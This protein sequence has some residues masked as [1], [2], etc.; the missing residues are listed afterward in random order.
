MRAYQHKT[1]L[2]R[3]ALVF[4]VALSGCYGPLQIPGI[5]P[6]I[7]AENPAS[8]PQKIWQSKLPSPPKEIL[9]LNDQKALITTFRGELF[10]LNLATGK[11]CS[12][13]WMPFRKPVQILLC[14]QRQGEIVVSGINDPKVYRYDLCTGRVLLETRLPGLDGTMMADEDGLFAVQNL[15]T[16]LKLTPLTFKVLAKLELP[17][18]VAAGAFAFKGRPALLT[19]DGHWR[20]YDKNLTLKQDLNLALNPY[21]VVG[22]YSDHLVIADSKGSVLILNDEGIK[23]RRELGKA[24]FAAPILDA[25]NLLVA[26][27]DGEVISI[28]W[29]NDKINWRW[30][31]AGPVG[32]KLW[33]CNDVLLVPYTRGKIVAIERHNGAFRWEI[34][35]D[36]ALRGWAVSRQGILTA[37]RDKKV[38]YWKW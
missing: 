1:W 21:P 22:F 15:R 28:N 27:A 38:A 4:F 2:R 31:G 11:R 9:I 12:R 24:I 18:N 14:D 35:T 10:L 32:R 30:Q 23:Y 8:P 5:T 36:R 19:T 34:T 16:L 37:D 20:V 6:E 17:T 13:F 26:C 3:G 7:C 25:D 29:R 33:I